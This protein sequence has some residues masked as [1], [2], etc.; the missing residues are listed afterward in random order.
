MSVQVAVDALKG[1]LAELASEKAQIESALSALNGQAE[2]SIPVPA[3]SKPSKARKPRTTGVAAAVE[4]YL[5]EHG[6]SS[7][8]D[9]AKALDLK[10]PQVSQ[11]LTQ[12][13]KKGKF[14]NEER[15]MWKVA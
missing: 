1:R 11:T 7:A 4:N 3:P 14:A 15:G 10:A 6:P 2:P 9:I 12:G 13:K 8:A 5:R